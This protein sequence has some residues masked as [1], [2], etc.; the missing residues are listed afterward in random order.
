MWGTGVPSARGALDQKASGRRQHRGCAV[1]SAIRRRLPLAHDKVCERCCRQNYMVEMGGRRRQRRD[2]ARPLRLMQESPVRLSRAAAVVVTMRVFASHMMV[3]VRFMIHVMSGRK[4][5]RHCQAMCLL[6]KGQQPGQHEAKRQDL[7]Q[8]CGQ[9]AFHGQ[10]LSLPVAGR[11][12]DMEI[13]SSA[14]RL[15]RRSPWLRP[16]PRLRV[17]RRGRGS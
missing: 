16:S 10:T 13:T 17:S 3:A 11:S 5:R 1:Q 14:Q 9:I 6:G 15:R 12:S 7:S 4:P 2:R 8:I